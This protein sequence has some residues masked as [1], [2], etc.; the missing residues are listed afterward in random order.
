MCFS[1]FGERKRRYFYVISKFFQ[2]N[3]T[4]KYEEESVHQ[5]L[6][7]STVARHQNNCHYSG[8]GIKPKI[9]CNILGIKKLNILKSQ[10]IQ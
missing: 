7:H 9:P 4:T 8:V 6:Q 5:F 2:E 1:R 10:N 3:G